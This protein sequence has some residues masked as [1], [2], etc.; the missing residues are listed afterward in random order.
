[1]EYNISKENYAPVFFKMTL[2]LRIIYLYA[3]HLVIINLVYIAFILQEAQ[4]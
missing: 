2:E 4:T 3:Q 1:M